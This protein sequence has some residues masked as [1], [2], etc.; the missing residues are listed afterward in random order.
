MI[1]KSQ[2]ISKHEGLGVTN[3]NRYVKTKGLVGGGNKWR[4]EPGAKHC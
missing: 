3:K 1:I 4:F 2:N